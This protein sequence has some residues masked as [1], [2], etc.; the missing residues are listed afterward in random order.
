MSWLRIR[1]VFLRHLTELR[2]TP[3]RANDLFVWPFID[4]LLFGSIGAFLALQSTG[5]INA[6]FVLSGLF[7]FHV[8]FQSSVALSIGFMSETGDRNLLNL[9]A[10]PLRAVEYAAGLV[11]FGLFKMSIGLAVTATLALVLFDYNVLNGGLALLPLIGALILVGIGLSF[12]LIS[13][14]LRFGRSAEQITWALAA[15]IP[16][17]SGAFVPVEALPGF[18]ETVARVLPTTHAFQ[19]VRALIQGQPLPLGDLWITLAGGLATVAIGVVAVTLSLRSFR[20]Q[21]LVGRYS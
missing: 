2:H 8:V 15:F 21:G 10:T 9:T 19:A 1:A 11:L 4:T 3:T 18:F 17:I 14:Q 16:T 20:R 12:C 5:E 7:M 6:A 13:L